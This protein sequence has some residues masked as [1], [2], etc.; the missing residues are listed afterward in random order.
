MSLLILAVFDRPAN[1]IYFDL[2]QKKS[3]RITAASH[4]GN[5]AENLLP[6]ASLNLPSKSG[7]LAPL[8][9]PSLDLTRRVPGSPCMLL[10]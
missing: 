10:T 4:L 2:R 5:P 1:S 3:Q 6:Q 9:S 7:P 8:A